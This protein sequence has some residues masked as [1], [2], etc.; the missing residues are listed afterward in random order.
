VALVL[1]KVELRDQLVTQMPKGPVRA[2][3]AAVV[4]QAGTLALKR[5]F[6]R[7]YELE[8]VTT[9]AAAVR[10]RWELPSGAGLMDLA[11]VMRVALGERD[12]DLS[13]IPA[14]VR[15]ETHIFSVMAVSELCG[16]SET[17]VNHLVAKAET[18]TFKRGWTPH[19]APVTTYA[20][21]DGGLWPGHRGCRLGQDSESFDAVAQLGSRP[22]SGEQTSGEA[23]W[24]RDS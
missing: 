22:Q 18:M 24:P 6:G 10:D 20:T 19:V 17:E 2:D 23:R 1:G 11:A 5:Y 7:D 9:F 3:D 14:A 16:W 8:A 4:E 21:P 15:A 13:E 12:V